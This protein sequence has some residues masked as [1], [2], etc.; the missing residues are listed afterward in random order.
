MNKLTISCLLTLWVF[1]ASAAGTGIELGDIIGGKNTRGADTNRFVGG[2]SRLTN[3]KTGGRGRGV[4]RRAGTGFNS[5]GLVGGKRDDFLPGS[6]SLLERGNF[7]GQVSPLLSPAV[8][9]IRV[10]FPHFC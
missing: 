1:A 2:A 6:R 3:R 8:T 4:T 9:T 10:V 5:G 7:L